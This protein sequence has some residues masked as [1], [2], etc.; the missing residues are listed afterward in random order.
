MSL[1]RIE[2]SSE[3]EGIKLKKKPL[4]PIII[5]SI[6]LC[7]RMARRKKI[8]IQVSCADSIMGSINSNLMEQAIINLIENAI[9]C[10]EQESSI[11]VAC[12][13]I[14]DNINI[15]VTDTDIGIAQEYLPRIFERFYR[16]DKARS[17]EL[18]GTGLGLA[19]MKHIAIAHGGKV[20]VT[21]TINQGSTFTIRI[22]GNN[23]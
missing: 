1:A 23:S 15:T 18:G 12:K 14:E 16:V 13:I 6:Q 19:I 10:S 17:R 2:Q 21:S 22:P 8:N 20:D 9:K 11:R 7:D 3:S 4:K 5:S